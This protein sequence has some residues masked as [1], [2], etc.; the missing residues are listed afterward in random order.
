MVI[1]PEWITVTAASR[2]A[3]VSDRT[4]RNWI[5]K[6]R[7]VAKKEKGRWLV[8]ESGLAEIGKDV[9]DVS[10][11][12]ESPETIPV[13]LEHYD[14]LM[15][16]L[17]QLEAENRQYRLMLEAHDSKLEQSESEKEQAKADLEAREKEIAELRGELAHYQQPFYRR[18]FKRRPKEN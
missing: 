4:I 15:T 11:K 10:G 1:L 18:W 7:I 6:G 17:G 9:S 3:G 13:P 16:R 12:S 5:D 8:D 2:K 14:G